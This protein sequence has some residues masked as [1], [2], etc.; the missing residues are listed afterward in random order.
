MHNKV[1]EDLP[2]EER[3]MRNLKTKDEQG[4]VS[5]C[6]VRLRHQRKDNMYDS[7]AMKREKSCEKR[8]DDINSFENSKGEEY[9]CLY[10]DSPL[11]EPCY[12][13]HQI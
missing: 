13:L 8:E 10:F 4:V 1:I 11:R 3:E 9:G 12:P 5:A 7:C 2:C 6:K